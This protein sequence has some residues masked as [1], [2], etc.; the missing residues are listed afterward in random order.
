MGCRQD[1]EC[2]VCNHVICSMGVITGD[3]LSVCA[4][5][6]EPGRVG[7]KYDWRCRQKEFVRILFVVVVLPNFSQLFRIYYQMSA[8]SRTPYVPKVL[9][10]RKNLKGCEKHDFQTKC[11]VPTI[12]RVVQG[13]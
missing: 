12:V 13:K 5:S 2:Q 6:H 7:N 10:L 9:P 3:L 1:G 11:L 8:E 4:R